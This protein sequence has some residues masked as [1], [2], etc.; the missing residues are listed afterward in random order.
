[1]LLLANAAVVAATTDSLMSNPSATESTYA[2]LAAS[3][4]AVGVATPLTLLLDIETVPVPV[5]VIVTEL[6]APVAASVGAA[7]L[8]TS[9][10]IAAP[11]TLPVAVKVRPCTV[12]E[13]VPLVAPVIAPALILAVPSVN[14]PP[15]TAPLN[16]AATPDV[17]LPLAILNVPSVTVAPC[18][19]A[20]AV[21]FV[22]ASIVLEAFKC[23]CYVT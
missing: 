4:V 6:S 20:T 17:I 5:G 23:S 22:P 19:V 1:M 11:F 8:N 14:V 7:P 10:I 13:N 15:C 3:V 21:M 2:L 18:T 12:A 9:E 16:V